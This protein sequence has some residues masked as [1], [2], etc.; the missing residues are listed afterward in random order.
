[1]FNRVYVRLAVTIVGMAAGILI[2][3]TLISMA[4]AHYHISM[5]MEQVSLA[6]KRLSPLMDHLESALI[7]SI[8]LTGLFSLLLALIIGVYFAKRISR[9]LVRMKQAAEWISR[10]NLDVRVG[11]EGKDEIAELGASLNQLSEQ[12]QRQQSLRM[13]MSQD[14]AHELRTP[15][16]TLKSHMRALE[17]G[18]WEPTPDRIHSCLEEV[19]RLIQLVSELE[20]LNVMDSPE[21]QLSC[22]EEPL[23]TIVVKAAGLME[24]AFME[25]QVQLQYEDVSEIKLL[26]D[27]DRMKQ[28]LVN[29]LTNALHHT[30]AGGTV[31][32]RERREKGAVCLVISDTGP[33]ISAKDL[34]YI[35]ERFYRGD[36]SRTRQTGGSGMGLAIVKKLV[37]AHGGEVWAQSDHEGARFYIRLPK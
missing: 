27:V 22:K 26:M 36:K 31:S 14:I 30:P 28:I 37:E 3:F 17:D 6:S 18:I 21:F 5:Y 13:S 8:L 2:I 23:R 25:K 7:Q 16:T 15:L 20:E 12:L 33:G 9:P 32:I 11:T 35:F 29:L 1:M 4:A 34:P 10:G 19:E 24:A